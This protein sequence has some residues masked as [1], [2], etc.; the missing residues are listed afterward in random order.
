MNTTL[1]GDSF[2]QRIRN[3]ISSLIEKSDFRL[4]LKGMDEMWIVPKDSK[5]FNKKKYVYP[6]G[7]DVVIDVSI[8]PPLSSGNDFLVL[9]E[10]KNLRNP[11]DVGDVGEF[12]NKVRLLHA[13]KGILISSN[14]FQTGAIEMAKYCNLALARVNNENNI[15]WYLHRIGYRD[16]RTYDTFR[17]EVKHRIL[18]NTAILDGFQGYTS[19]VDYFSNLLFLEPTVL[20]NKVPYL[21]NADIKKEVANF[22]NGRP[23]VKI[24]NLELRFYCIKNNINV[25]DDIDCHGVQGRCDFL[26]NRIYI[27]PSLKSDKH[28]YRF[29]FAHEIGHSYLH[30]KLLMKIISSAEDVDLDRQRGG[31]DWEKRLEIQANLFASYL[32]IPENPMINKYF[33]VKREL[34]YSDRQRLYLDNQPVNIEDCN[35]VFN[36]LSRFFNVS[37]Q[38]VKIRLLDDNLLVENNSL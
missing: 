4:V 3:V 11:V 5:T 8:E 1:K 12:I 9:V 21:T 27:D 29:V 36:E 7:R 20:E 14:G 35:S 37:K 33:E 30:R 18:Y 10:C 23:Y 26:N 22:L 2:E 16:I 25:F 24:S 15:E 34:G 13:T 31:A 17:R 32:L 19:L 38:M 6:Y 28:R